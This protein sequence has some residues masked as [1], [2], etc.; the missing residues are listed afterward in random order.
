L[1]LLR[2]VPSLWMN[3][4]LVISLKVFEEENT[5]LTTMFTEEENF[6]LFHDVHNGD[7]KLFRI[8]FGEIILVTRHVIVNKDSYVC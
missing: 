1:E 5:I 7:L 6:K 2:R 8:V 3:P 4:R